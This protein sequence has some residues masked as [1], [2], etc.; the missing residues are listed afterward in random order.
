MTNNRIRKTFN[1]LYYRVM[2]DRWNVDI[3]YPP[4]LED[5]LYPGSNYSYDWTFSKLLS[6]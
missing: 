5:T 2:E 3:P 1:G 6:G 4:G